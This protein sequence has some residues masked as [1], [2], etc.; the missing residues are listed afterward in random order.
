MA[1]PKFLLRDPKATGKTLIFLIYRI[2]ETRLKYST[3]ETI[4]PGYWDATRQSATET[5]KGNKPL[6]DSLKTIN[7]QLNRYKNKVLEIETYWKTQKID[8]NIKNLKQELDK[9]FKKLPE[10]VPVPDPEPEPDKINL[11]S[12]IETY[13]SNVRFTRTVPPKPIN[14]RTIQKYRTTQRVLKEFAA[15]KRGGKL[16]F[17]NIDLLFY[18]DFTEYLQKTYKHTPNTIGK[19]IR[20]LK[21]FLKEA[22]EAG[23]NTNHLFESKKFAAPTETVE[24]IY[25]NDQEL[26]KLYFLDLSTCKRLESV[27]DLF[28][29]SCYTG[30]R[31]QDFTTITPENIIDGK[32]KLKISTQKTGQTVVIPI[33]WRVA[34]ILTRYENNLPRAISNQKM[35]EYLKELAK[36]AEI[37]DPVQIVKTKGGKREILNFGKCELV[38]CHTGRRTFATNLYKA[39]VPAQSIMKLTGHKTEAVFM[40]YLNI[41]EDENANILMNHEYFTRGRLRAV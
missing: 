29:V 11:F 20:N 19:Y 31:F 23:V 25:L 22:T 18:Q 35:N 10:P 37:T 6:L 39:G 9:E 15:K 36:L 24:H 27:R 14:P 8:P 21:V 32:T 16:D 1:T 2:G 7:L 33:H 41:G 4:D 12:F 17:E 30:L 34:E 5:I 28:L 26:D 13:I 3:G 40:K 38:T